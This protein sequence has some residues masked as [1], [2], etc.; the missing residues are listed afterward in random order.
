MALWCTLLLPM[1]QSE[2]DMLGKRIYSH[3]HIVKSKQYP[4]SGSAVLILLN[5]I[6]KK[7]P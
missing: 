2:F 6:H 3:N 7:G 1:K 5:A 4:Q